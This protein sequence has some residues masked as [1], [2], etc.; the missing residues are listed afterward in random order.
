MIVS[1]LF[2]IEEVGFTAKDAII[3]WPEEIPPNIPPALLDLNFIR[4]DA[5][6]ISSEF[7]SPD[8]NR[9]HS[10]LLRYLHLLLRLCSLMLKLYQ[11][12]SLEYIGAPRPVGIPLALS[13]ITAPH[14]DPDFLTIS[15]NIFPKFLQKFLSGQKKIFSYFFIA[16][17]VSVTTHYT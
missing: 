4:P 7:S 5:F 9:R 8:L 16:P 6:L 2:K 17:F 10:Y 3:S 12:L 1:L 13:S 15:I 11:H 14:D